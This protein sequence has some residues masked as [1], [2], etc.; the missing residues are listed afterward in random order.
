MRVAADPDGLDP[1]A[2]VR[3]AAWFVARAVHRGLMAFPSATAGLSGTR[4]VPD[5]A[6]GAPARVA[7]G[8]RF[9]LRSDVRFRDGR[10]ITGAD[11]AASI[12]RLSVTKRGI[13]RFT[14]ALG[15]ADVT[16]DSV[17]I[18][19]GR[20][21]LLWL[22]AQPQAAI[23]P[24]DTR[25]WG[26][27]AASI[28]GAGPYSIAAF[29]PG[30][31]LRLVRNLNWEARTDPV[32][33]ANVDAIEFTVGSTGA[34]AREHVAAGRL[35]L[36]LDP[37]PPDATLPSVPTQRVGVQNSLCVRSLFLNVDVAPFRSV[38]ARAAVALAVDRSKLPGVP[39]AARQARSLLP[40]DV[41]GSS[42]DGAL[43]PDP[44]GAKAQ[45][46]AAGLAGSDRL[47]LTVADSPRDRAEA[48]SLRAAL[49]RAGI[50]VRVKVVRPALLYPDHY[51]NPGA[52]T[53]MGIA[54]W[55]AEWPGLAGRSAL[56]PLVRSGAARATRLSGVR[57]DQIDALL[58]KAADGPGWRAADLA[59]RKAG[60][61]I[62]LTWPYE[63]SPLS[64]RLRGWDSSP[65][66]SRGDP[67]A[68]WLAT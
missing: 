36:I 52:R 65:M 42:T 35:D 55:C 14:A 21:D 62:P 22:L 41:F 19:G 43:A 46:R 53:Q 10:K 12:A 11:V 66:F 23:V 33:G 17:T 6:A 54:T 60:V 28:V 58:T 59:A 57:G 67:G 13:G 27:A 3:P 39:T 4:P 1:H 24:A 51:A 9:T 7:T 50:G 34:T 29:E 64:P 49:A 8:W 48:S 30:R 68:L 45:W 63:V 38:R 44:T 15:V 32:R 20:P 5:L 56:S 40:P 18:T 61:L 26:V 16:A 37:G 25:P 47:T 31:S 2:A